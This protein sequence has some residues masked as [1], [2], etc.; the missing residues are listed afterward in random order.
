[1]WHVWQGYRLSLGRPLTPPLQ[2]ERVNAL[3]AGEGFLAQH[4]MRVIEGVATTALQTTSRRR[5]PDT[6]VQVAEFR[7]ERCK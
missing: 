7:W 1:M 6:P 5:A 3:I 2:G 4:A